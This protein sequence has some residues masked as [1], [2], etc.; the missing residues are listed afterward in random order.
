MK[1]L[2]MAGGRGTR[3]WPASRRSRPKQFLNIAGKRTML[4]DTMARLEGLLKPRDIFI[5]CAPEFVENVRVQ[6]P[7]YDPKRIIVEPAARSTAA[8]VGY[9]ALR[10]RRDF[11]DEVMAV[12]PADHVVGNVEELHRVCT[13]AEMLARDGWL[14]TFGIRPD[15]P[16]LG[17]GYIERGDLIGMDSE[18]AAYTVKS[19]LEKPNRERARQMVEGGRH[20][21]NS[22]IFVWTAGAI[23]A[24]IEEF[25]PQLHRVLV[26][27]DRDWDDLERHQRLFVGLDSVSIDY[28]VLEKAEKVAVIPCDLD[29]N[30]VGNWSAL[31]QL[32]PADSND[33]VSSGPY[34]SVDSRNCVLQAS[35]GKLVALLGVEDLVIVETPDAVLVCRRERTEEVR[36]IVAELEAGDMTEYL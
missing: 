12:M 8:C 11:P 15:G 17:Y 10:L 7:G 18:R 5:V 26:E 4:Q 35:H 6:V 30:D 27:I 33:I 36:K 34:L 31:R 21:W 24:A 22:G 3:F 16:S 2:I 25:M 13:A 28:G 23:L 29:W 32:L 19:F 14:V 1:A 20:D 9:A